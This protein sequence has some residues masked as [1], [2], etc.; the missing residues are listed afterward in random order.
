MY[1]FYQACKCPK[2]S[3]I[4]CKNCEDVVIGYTRDSTASTA[5][6]TWFNEIIRGERY[7]LIEREDW[8]NKQ[9]AKEMDTE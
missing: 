3:D 4:N 2:I 9:E 1:K 8:K 7:D 5:L 6:D